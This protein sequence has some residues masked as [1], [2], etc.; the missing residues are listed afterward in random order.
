MLEVRQ[1]LPRVK[2]CETV[3][4]CQV[5]ETNYRTSS[6]LASPFSFAYCRCLLYSLISQLLHNHITLAD[7]LLSPWTS[8]LWPLNYNYRD[9]GNNHLHTWIYDQHSNTHTRIYIP[10]IRCIYEYNYYKQI[11]SC[12]YKRKKLAVLSLR[13]SCYSKTHMYT[14]MWMLNRLPPFIC[15]IQGM[16][17]ICIN[18]IYWVSLNE[19]RMSRDCYVRSTYKYCVYYFYSEHRYPTRRLSDAEFRVNNLVEYIVLILQV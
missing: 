3:A 19:P 15:T 11:P 14:H 8:T 13:I 2:T 17:T 5:T 6:D 16:H 12:W 10:W 4:R 1:S 18:L 9:P 7:S